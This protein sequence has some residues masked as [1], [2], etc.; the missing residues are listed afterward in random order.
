VSEQAR[1]LFGESYPSVVDYVDLLAHQGVEWGLIGPRE[2]DRLWERHILN[3]VAVN[4]LVP[5]GASVVDVG[6]GAG[7]PGIPL[8]VL[9]P[10]LRVTLL[11]PLLR[12]SRFLTQAVDSLGITGRVTV[13]RSRAEDCDQSFDV[14]LSRAL[15]P[16]GRLVD[17][18][19]PLRSRE[20]SILAIKGSSAASEVESCRRQLASRHLAAAVLVVRAHPQSEPTTV[21]RLGPA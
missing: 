10:D 12:R 16:L 18:C 8:A 14:V 15:A 21:V 11:E 17:W 3:S 9:R 4:H 7:L 19:A 2:V 13:L 6:S 5:Q 1:E 20:C